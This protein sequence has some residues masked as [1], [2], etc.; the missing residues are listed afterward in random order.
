MK[1]TEYNVESMESKVVRST[2]SITTGP[3]TRKNATECQPNV[4]APQLQP[5]SRFLLNFK[6]YI[7]KPVQEKKP[8]CPSDIASPECESL[9]FVAGS[10]SNIERY[11]NHFQAPMPKTILSLGREFNEHGNLLNLN[12]GN[13]GRLRTSR[14]QDNIEAVRQSVNQSPEKGNRRC[15]QELGL[16]STSV[17]TILK[18]ELK[19][20]LYKNQIVSYCKT[21][22]TP[23]KVSGLARPCVEKNCFGELKNAPYDFI[24]PCTSVYMFSPGTLSVSCSKERLLEKKGLREGFGVEEMLIVSISGPESLKSSNSSK[25]SSISVGSTSPPIDKK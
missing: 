3:R 10:I 4:S 1:M 18:E 15:A 19:T 9:H 13:S 16:R 23:E 5:S 11:R 25:R 21:S 20:Y 8:S 7:E 17:R 12:K 24:G 14:T 2:S 22:I 6:Q